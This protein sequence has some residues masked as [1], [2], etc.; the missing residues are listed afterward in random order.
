LYCIL[1]NDSESVSEVLL[2]VE[3]ERAK[4]KLIELLEH[5][6]TLALHEKGLPDN[7]RE[8]YQRWVSE[9]RKFE[10]TEFEGPRYFDWVSFWRV[11]P[12]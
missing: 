1:K 12:Q 8:M 5:E 4:T 7:I 11:N 10:E 3:F 9:A 6:V 2:F